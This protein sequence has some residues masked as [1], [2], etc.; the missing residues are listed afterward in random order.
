MK[1]AN[2]QK[3]AVHT[4][5]QQQRKDAFNDLQNIALE[6]LKTKYPNFPYPPKP[7]YSDKNANALTKCVIDYIQ[8]NGGQA[9]RI[10]STGRQI[11]SGNGYK[12]IR[13]NGTNGTADISATIN[14]RSVKIEIKCA[15]T[16]DTTQSQ[17]QK[18]YQQAVE[19]AG[20]VYIL[21]HTFPDFYDWFNS[22]TL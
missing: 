2:T 7:K 9:E 20:G 21:V 14:G 16:G 5:L 12:W 4:T 15:A 3:A 18:N 10:N 22:N 6:A 8:F 1:G 13:N 19:A 17:E 11:K